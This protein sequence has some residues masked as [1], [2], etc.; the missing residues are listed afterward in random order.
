MGKVLILVPNDILGGAEQHLKNIA[1]YMFL[2]GYQVDVFFLK[3]Q[4]GGGWQDLATN[5]NLV[6]TNSRKE[7]TGVGACFIKLF[8][9]RKTKYNYVFTSHV[10]LNSFVGLLIKLGVIK[11]N[12]FIGRESTSIFKRF[13]GMKLCLYKFLYKL[14]YSSI[15]LLICQTDF[16]KKQLTEALP[17]LAATIN[18]QVIGN[19][20]NLVNIQTDQFDCEYKKEDYIVSAGRLIELK[21][22]DLLI[23]SFALIKDRFPNLKLFILG[24]GAERQGL[25]SLAVK[26][27]VQDRVRL[28]GFQNNVYPFFK[29]AKICVVS[30]RIEGFPNVLLQMM[31][32][33]DNIVSTLCAGGID[34]I[35]SI[36]T[37]RPNDIET[38]TDKIILALETDNANNRKVF[39]D[40]LK[41]RSLAGFIERINIYLGV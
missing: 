1:L 36:Y 26:L 19:P 38:L 4:T 21:G 40:F 20:I 5:L 18:I 3:K 9:N 23:Q 29:N 11:K 22:F 13:K 32:Q 28:V 31:S 25:E 8:R 37:C 16:M 15:D 39:D 30:S 35:P 41:T 33:N 6:F 27:G 34:Q 2:E 7:R 10:H 14:G 17:S 12:F 24:E